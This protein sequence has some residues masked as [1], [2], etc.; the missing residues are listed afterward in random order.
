MT[1]REKELLS[2]EIFADNAVLSTV[3]LCQ[4]FAIEERRVVEWVAEGVLTTVELN[5]SEWRFS[6]T[7][8]RRARIALR[9]ERDLGVNVPGV[10]LV[11]DLLEELEHLRR[12]T[13][14]ERA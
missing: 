4:M 10:A 6:G 7:A 3:E 9:L 13:R 12:L 14:A 2:G 11:L 8:A 5:T 1:S